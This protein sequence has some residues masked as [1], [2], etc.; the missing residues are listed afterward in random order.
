M[1]AARTRA[2]PAPRR[3]SW[4]RL[5]VLVPALLALLA[6][7]WGGLGRLGVAALGV[8]PLFSQAVVFHAALM[9]SGFFGTVIGL[10]RAVAVGR[11]WAFASPLA[12]GAGALLMLLGWSATGAWLLVAAALVFVAASVE[13]VRRQPVLHVQVL[14]VAALA[15]LLGNLGLATGWAM[16][17]VVAWWFAFLVV[18]IAAER[19]EMTRLMRRRR[20]VQAA[21]LVLLAALLLGA[22]VTAFDPSAGGVIYGA[23]LALLG[24]WLAGFDTARRT[25][26]SRGLSRYMAL[27]LLAGYFWLMVA[28]LAWAGMAL[29]APTRDAAFHA[30][31]L[32]FVVSMVMAHA[33][34]ILPAVAGVKLR[35]GVA[36]YVP[37]ALLHASLALR[38]WGDAW[39]PTLRRLGAEL[40]VAALL[41]FAATV[42]I[43]AMLGRREVH[44][45]GRASRP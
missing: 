22:A 28:G 44:G 40:N 23:A 36:F 31:G 27:C 43:A 17:A 7:M 25:V 33:P 29:G 13:I 26:A 42:L 30:L 32:G 9:I 6:G 12:C 5:L 18:T 15:W 41:L 35:F 39:S 14:Q 10:E 34:V 20:C 45:A 38:L 2:A 37:L 4:L 16:Q 1:N 19:L 24:G 3:A 21:L 8:T 11:R